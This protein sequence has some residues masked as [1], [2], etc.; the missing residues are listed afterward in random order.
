[1]ELS[2]P[3]YQTLESVFRKFLSDLA[4]IYESLGYI[5][6]WVSTECF[7]KVIYSCAGVQP[8]LLQALSFTGHK[9]ITGYSA[10]HM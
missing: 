1:M 2:F 10:V 8:T 9:P 3:D 5:L 4:W 6:L 7:D